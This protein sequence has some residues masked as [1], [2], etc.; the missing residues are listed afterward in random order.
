MI[1]QLSV[2]TR[3]LVVLGMIFLLQCGGSETKKEDL[4]KKITTENALEEADKLIQE[5]ENL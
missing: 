1:K 3:I 4:T 5:L 2:F